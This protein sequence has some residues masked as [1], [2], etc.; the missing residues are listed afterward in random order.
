MGLN[1]P[2]DPSLTTSTAQPA[3]YIA[4]NREDGTSVNA[5]L[6]DVHEPLEGK[7]N[8]GGMSYS[9]SL[10]TVPIELGGTGA[11]DAQFAINN[12]L[13]FALLPGGS[14]LY[15][16][17]TNWGVLPPGAE[18]QGL[19]IAN[20]KPTWSHAVVSL[21]QTTSIITSSAEADLPN[22]TVLKG[23]YGGGISVGTED[24]IT[25]LAVDSTVARTNAEEVFSGA[26]TFKKGV[27]TSG[28]AIAPNDSA[29]VVAVVLADPADDRT[30]EIPECGLNADFVM[31]QG[32][33]TIMGE[34]HF[35]NL[36]VIGQ[37]LQ[38]AQTIQ[39]FP[40]A[41]DTL[42]NCT[43]M[44][45]LCNKIFD[46]IKIEG[47]IKLHDASIGYT[48]NWAQPQAQRTYSFYD[49]NADGDIAI[50][51]GNPT[52]GGIAYAD[53]SVIKFTQNGTAGLPLVSEG[54]QE[55][56]F[57]PLKEMGG[58]TGQIEYAPGDMLFANAAGGLSRLAIGK[59]G[60]VLS[61]NPDGAPCWKDK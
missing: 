31:S 50:K 11:S 51:S 49:A 47:E 54:L 44:Q 39:T 37:T 29:H 24:D 8:G 41:S 27:V 12:I 6:I 20:G 33:Q 19:A 36:H 32:K 52:R 58:G 56:V 34:K 2:I 38:T 10:K 25:G 4:V 17:G 43:S 46:G 23:A 3:A 5:R 22:A 13:S 21:P 18:G 42:V 57:A 35:S 7:D 30:Y 1:L 15:C 60:Q 45:V 55:P 28:I 53:G 9:I 59:S 48:I 26:V 14:L 61:I 40:E 16:D